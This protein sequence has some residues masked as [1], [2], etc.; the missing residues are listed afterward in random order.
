VK[1]DGMITMPVNKVFRYVH[2]GPEHSTR[3]YVAAFV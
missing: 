2:E 1:A 3:H